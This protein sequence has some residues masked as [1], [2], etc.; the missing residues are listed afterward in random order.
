MVLFKNYHKNYYILASVEELN[1]RFLAI[2]FEIND[3]NKG[4]MI[5]TFKNLI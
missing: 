5:I 4:L 1:Q 3:R 2:N